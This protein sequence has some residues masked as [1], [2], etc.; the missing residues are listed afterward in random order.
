M[1]WLSCDNASGHE[2]PIMTLNSI[3]RYPRRTASI[4]LI[5]VFMSEDPKSKD[6]LAKHGQIAFEWDV[7]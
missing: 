4:D 3:L 6:T 1:R 2:Q 7:L 5:G